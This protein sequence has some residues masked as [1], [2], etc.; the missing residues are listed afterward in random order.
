[1]GAEPPKSQSL[2][3]ISRGLQAGRRRRVGDPLVAVAGCGW[4]LLLLARGVS[5]T[6]RDARQLVLL[7][8]GVRPV[9]ARTS[10]NF[11]RFNTLSS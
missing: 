7:V 8:R 4:K 9:F 6:P 2:P 11:E 3:P 10:N 1:M 5:V